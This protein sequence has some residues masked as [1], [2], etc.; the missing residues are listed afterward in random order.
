MPLGHLLLTSNSLEKKLFTD[1]P[2]FTYFKNIYKK[3]SEFS[4]ED[5][6]QYLIND[7]GFSK[8]SSCLLHNNADL[9]NNVYFVATL[10]NIPYLNEFELNGISFR[11]ID[12][13]GEKL[14]KSIEL[15][16][17]NKI[18]QKIT[19]YHINIYNKLFTNNNKNLDK[20]I[21]NVPE[22]IN[23]S[24]KKKEYKLYIP[25]PFWFSES[26]GNSFPINKFDI[27][28]I[29]INIELESIE[30][31]LIY[32]PIYYITINEFKVN[33]KKYE[34]IY[35]SK[36][37]VI[38]QFFYFDENKKR[39]YYNLISDNN[40]EYFENIN[41]I[42]SNI[43]N[44]DSSYFITD[45]KK[46]IYYT[47]IESYKKTEINFNI[48]N[49]TL[50]NAYFQIRYIFLDKIE[51]EIIKKSSKIEYLIKQY[52]YIIYNNIDSIKNNFDINGKNTV[53][54]ISWICILHSD[55]KNKFFF[56]Y[57]D[58]IINSSLS[59]NSF[60]IFSKRNNNFIK[61][62]NQFYNYNTNKVH[63]INSYCFTNNILSYQPSG[64]LNLSKIEKCNLFLEFDKTISIN[65]KLDVYI[66]ISYY[67][68]LSIEKNKIEIY[69]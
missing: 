4:I 26:I 14:I 61:L 17:N 39:L 13:I 46:S 37:N 35:Q 68:I 66:I 7:Y 38:A 69:F 47:P 12:N 6:N 53:Y 29:K 20:M 1:N 40:F 31:L 49:I 58:K 18:I 48:N 50:N 21:G 9:I 51:Q 41:K 33:F 25:I 15:E 3:I 2:E 42:Y 62:V 28:Q 22:N 52:K 67:N 65:N 34:Y 60:D 43:I 59:I 24:N 30:N 44:I 10:P 54:D 36:N 11:W 64:S 57:A 63:N 19:G 56:N 16:I 45:K 32:G 27:N 5:I 55:I 8:R 23:F